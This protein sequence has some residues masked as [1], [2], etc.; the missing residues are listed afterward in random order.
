MTTIERGLRHVRLALL[1]V[2][3]TSVAASLAG[4]I[5]WESHWRGW[6][7]ETP[8]LHIDNPWTLEA[9]WSDLDFEQ[10]ARMQSRYQSRFLRQGHVVGVFGLFGLVGVLYISIFILHV[11]GR[12][13][14]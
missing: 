4:E 3:A 2:A 6:R 7:V 12:N 10:H 8:S 11:S 5:W 9:G 14:P 1:I 13:S